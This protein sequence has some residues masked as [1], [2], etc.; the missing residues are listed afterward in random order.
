MVRFSL[1]NHQAGVLHKVLHGPLL[2]LQ[3]KL[4]RLGHRGLDGGVGLGG[5]RL[6]LGRYNGRTPK[7]GVLV[8][9]HVSSDLFEAGGHAIALVKG[10]QEGAACLVVF[11]LGLGDLDVV[12]KVLGDW[13]WRWGSSGSGSSWSGGNTYNIFFASYIL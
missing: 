4:G 12:K 2:A 5:G 6:G 10:V 9:L 13:R 1:L 8:G 7:I 3:F 11:V